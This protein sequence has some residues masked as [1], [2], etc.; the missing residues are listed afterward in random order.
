VSIWRRKRKDILPL[1]KYSTTGLHQSQVLY[2]YL[3]A[4]GGGGRS[5]AVGE[6]IKEPIKLFRKE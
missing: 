2:F 4:V 6:N 1:F 3:E 5:H